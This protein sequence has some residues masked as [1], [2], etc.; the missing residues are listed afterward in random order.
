MR[1][2]LTVLLALCL[3]SCGP[4]QTQVAAVAVDLVKAPVPQ[5]CDVSA[6]EK[7]P[8]VKAGHKTIKGASR[9]SD[10]VRAG[11][12]GRRADALNYVRALRCQCEVTMSYG[13]EAEK[14]ELDGEI[15]SLSFLKQLQ[16]EAEAIKDV[17]AAAVKK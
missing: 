3:A 17:P 10:W 14:A 6:W 13:S 9:L 8:E 16:L 15:C 11:A 7:F 1:F 12:V 2:L 5:S 4:S